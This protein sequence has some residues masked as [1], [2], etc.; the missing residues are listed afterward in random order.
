MPGAQK[1]EIAKETVRIVMVD[2][3]SL[4][5]QYSEF[6]KKETAETRV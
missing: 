1:G 4:R 5:P 6:S 2:A 3:P